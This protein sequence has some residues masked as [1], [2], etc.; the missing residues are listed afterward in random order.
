MPGLDDLLLP[1]GTR[2]VHIG[3]H[4]TGTTAIQAAF[5]ASRERVAAHGV[6]YAWPTPQAYRPALAL[7]GRPGQ[8]GTDGVVGDE[9]DNLVAEIEGYGDDRVVLSSESLSNAEPDAIARLREDLGADRIHVVTMVRRYDALLPSLWQQRVVGGYEKPW[10]AYLR[11]ILTKPQ[12]PFWPHFGIASMAQ[13]WAEVVGPDRVTVVVVNDRDHGW[14][15]GVVARMVGLPD[16]VLAP[17]GDAR[18]VNRSLTRA[19]AEMLR[20]TNAVFNSRSW[21]DEALRFY[22]RFGVKTALKPFPADPAEG[23]AAVPGELLGRLEEFTEAHW[24]DLQDV[25]VRV[26]GERAWL[27]P[28][29]TTR[30]QTSEPLTVPV[31]KVAAA[32]ASV[33]ERAALPGAPKL[34]AG[35]VPDVRPP[36]AGAPTAIGL[37]ARLR[38]RRERSSAANAT[39][40][41]VEA[42]EAARTWSDQEHRRYIEQGLLPWLAAADRVTGPELAEGRVLAE[43]AGTALAG[44][45]SR[46]P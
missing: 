9:W 36:S 24:R 41:L 46:V 5:H 43:V 28:A 27:Q 25:G 42:V 22:L 10:E 30:T 29:A 44:V 19:E 7:T 14:L 2:L 23:R 18:A 20:A 16:G 3:P 31:E 8:R 6:H 32:I 34:G 37:R 21:S 39:R 12:H 17:G 33:A 11:R 26:V 1:P 38:R 45:I 40:E 35:K 13:R 15:P 4:K